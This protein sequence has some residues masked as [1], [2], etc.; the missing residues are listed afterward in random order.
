[1]LVF[2]V[3]ILFLLPHT[4]CQHTSS[5]TLNYLLRI[6][7]EYYQP[8]DLL[9]GALASHIFV[10]LNKEDFR[11]ILTT[12]QLPNLFVVPKNYQHLL[13]LV[14]AVKE[15]N[16]NPKILP[17]ITLG[18]H[19][20]DSY[21]NRRV[22]YQ[23]TL[24]LPS[25]HVPNY[26]CDLQKNL[27]AVIGGL[28]FDTSLD[29]ATIL[30]IY[31]IPQLTYGSFAPEDPGQSQSTSSYRMV[32]NE[33]H[34]YSG[35]VELLLHFGWTWV[36]LLAGDNESGER[37]TQTLQHLLSQKGIC[38]AFSERTQKTRHF[39]EYFHMHHHWTRIYQVIMESKAK[40]VI[41]YG[42]TKSML[43][44]RT[45]VALGEMGDV[46]KTP[47]GKVWILTAQ[48]DFTALTFQITWDMEVF[49]GS[50][51]FAVH[52]NEVQGFKS[53]LQVQNPFEANGNGFLKEFW[54]EVFFCSFPGFNT[55]EAASEACTG[56]EK[57]EDLPSS[58]F[59][60][61]MSG[62]SYS[63]YNAAYATAHALHVMFLSRTKYRGVEEGGMQELQKLQSWQVMPL[64]RYNLFDMS[65]Q[66]H[67]FLKRVSFNN[68]A[69]ETVSFGENREVEAGFD[70]TSMITFPNNSFVR[71]KVGRV[72]L[73]AAPGQ[74]FSIDDDKIVWHRNFS[75]V[76]P[77]SVC[78][79][80]CPPG[81]HKKKKEGGKFCC[82]DCAPCPQDKISP[83]KDMIDCV[84]CSE[85]HYP[86]KDKTQCIPKIISFLTYEEPL[87]LSIVFI[88]LFFSLITI[89]VLVIFIKHRDTPIVRANNRDLTYTLL[90]FLLLCFL[91]P[92]IFL[93]PPERVSC[94]L[95][96]M[97][98]GLV[99]TVTVS[100]L[101]AKTIT[102][103]LAFVATKPGSRM[104]KWVGKRLASSIVISCSLIQV[105]ICTVWLGTSPPFPDSDMHSVMRE[106]ILGC[107][108]GSVALFYCVLGYMGFLAIVSFVVAFFAR[109]LPESFNEAK[110]ITFSMFMFCSVWVSFVPVYLS[111]KGKYMVAVEIFSILASSAGL[112]GSIFA[113]KC[114]VIILRPDQNIREQLIRK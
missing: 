101:L 46:K 95:R 114:Y 91:C 29:M 65:M 33:A 12:H 94:L 105:G 53:V 73:E 71:V 7:H 74:E 56:E 13:A 85:D 38:L 37:F 93:S 79:P 10:A 97:A 15:I 16:E 43:D 75:Q 39:D 113:P 41:V 61:T 59:E 22:T 58:G 40:V 23:A 64:M 77:L 49:H 11:G 14:F 26:R 9:I 72:D 78:N 82:Y 92:L 67:P 45:M 106:I 57:L 27:M 31:K 30:D 102:V 44:F 34:Q 35:I 70:M 52:S 32:P 83:Q 20:Y 98:F 112:L 18:F 19:I 84:G 2:I 4:V 103:V 99:F 90:T 76:P 86:N 81:S 63:L 109:K 60:M 80:S 88:S 17:N 36:G 107:N 8:G 47:E 68:S 87:G 1:M 104:R 100:C 69:G 55:E 3:S 28:D 48:L 110:F 51:S 96:Q 24:G 66:L 89:L 21:F 108:E 50:L 54:E 25:T 6:P 111:T 42:E 62:H 5:C